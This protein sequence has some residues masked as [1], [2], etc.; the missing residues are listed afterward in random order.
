MIDGYQ[1]KSWWATHGKRLVVKNIRYALGKTDKNEQ[2]F[3]TASK[4]PEYFWYFNN[5]ITLIADRATRAP[6]AA[7]SHSSG[8]FGLQGASIVNGAQ[9]VSTIARVIEDAQLGKV[10]VPIRVILLEKAPEGFGTSVTRTNNLQ[11]RVE[12]RDFVS[13][14][15]EQHRIQQEM[16]IEGIAYDFLRSEETSSS[17]NSCELIEVTTAL[18]CSS[19][20]PSHFIAVKTGVGR[21]FNDLSKA[22]YKALYNPNTSGAK[23]FNCV[24]VLRKIDEWITTKKATI[25]K[26]SGYPWGVL[27][28]GNRALAALVFKKLDKKSLDVPIKDFRTDYGD[29]IEAICEEIYPNLIEKL[30]KDRPN[31]FLAVL[32]KSPAKG[33][34][35]YEA[36]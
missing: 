14:D 16:R 22:P 4:N 23:A 7:S 2:I 15:S 24:R 34:E 19:G 3:E 36:L 8:T 28:H 9:T 29:E 27:V 17:G 10:K 33:R 13:Q 5:G 26:R 11:N 20:D 35:I 12:G 25:G 21:F 30:E 31:K 1:L 32:F 6:A 18:A